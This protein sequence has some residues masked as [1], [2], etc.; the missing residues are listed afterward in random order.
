M[1]PAA[2]CCR[3]TAWKYIRLPLTAQATVAACVC[4]MGQLYTANTWQ[5]L[6]SVFET[7]DTHVWHVPFWTDVVDTLC[8]CSARRDT[9]SSFVNFDFLLF[10]S[11]RRRQTFDVVSCDRRHVIFSVC[12]LTQHPRCKN[13]N[14]SFYNSGFTF[15]L[16][17]Q[18]HTNTPT[19]KWKQ[20][21]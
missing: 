14:T 8:E 1:V 15:V 18:A 5:G 17:T 13:H 10:S 9:P 7:F 2:V 19:L 11:P 16:V 12:G 6:M 21:V 4:R 3:N 20:R